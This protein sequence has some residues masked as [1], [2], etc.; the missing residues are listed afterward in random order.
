MNNQL[1]GLPRHYRIQQLMSHHVQHNP[2]SLEE[3]PSVEKRPS[4]VS[5]LGGMSGEEGLAGALLGLLCSRVKIV[6]RLIRN[7]HR[8]A[9]EANS[10]EKVPPH[11]GNALV[12]LMGCNVGK[13]SKL[14]S[15]V[16]RVHRGSISESVLPR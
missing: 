9:G 15:I 3:G 14:C 8:I 4:T 5:K 2:P 12:Y 13:V 7:K 10:V 1:P 6:A 11:C 16:I